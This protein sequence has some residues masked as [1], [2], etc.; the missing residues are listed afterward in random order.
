VTAG[1]LELPVHRFFMQRDDSFYEIVRGFT[2]SDRSKSVI[3]T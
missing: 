3:Y 1:L 2:V